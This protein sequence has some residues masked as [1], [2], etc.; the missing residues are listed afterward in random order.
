[1]IRRVIAPSTQFQIWLTLAGFRSQFTRLSCDTNINIGPISGH[2]RFAQKPR[3]DFAGGTIKTS[4]YCRKVFF[5]ES[6]LNHRNNCF[7]L[8]RS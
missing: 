3:S 8:I 4:K 1:M 7:V 5:E 2:L 6:K